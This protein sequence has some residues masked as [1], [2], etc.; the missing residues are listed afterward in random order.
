[1][2]D[3]PRRVVTG[4]T[5]DGVSV[6]LS[7]GPVPVSR[8]LPDDGVSFHEIWN[9]AG[10]P[11]RITATEDEPT[12]QAPRR[13]AAAARHQ[14][15]DQRVPARA[16]R[17]TRAPV[18]GAPH[19]LDRLRHRAR[20]ADHPRPR[21]LRGD[22]AR[23]R[24]GRPA[25]HRP[26]L[27]EP[28]RHHRAGGLHPGR[29]RSSTPAWPPPCPAASPDSCTA[30]R[31]TEAVGARAGRVGLAGRQHHLGGAA[32]RHGHGQLEPVAVQA[33]RRGDPPVRRVVLAPA[34]R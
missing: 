25:R 1:M 9:T 32:R 13:T 3:V 28:R 11:A 24:R 6:V 33:P 4:H 10:A 31:G 17:R 5:A 30:A 8:D 21:R 15:P 23:R 26:R 7:D 14:D 2:S 16:P 18:T 20:R 34:P 22:P 19:R 27:G 29:R 12:A